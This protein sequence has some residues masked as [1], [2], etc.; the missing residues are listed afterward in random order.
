MSLEGMEAIRG[1]LV[2]WRGAIIGR[3]GRA[4]LRVTW[5]ISMM[6]EE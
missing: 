3:S 2:K 6:L 1:L 5:H 4:I